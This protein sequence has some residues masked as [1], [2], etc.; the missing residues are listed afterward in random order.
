M[1]LTMNVCWIA[2]WLLYNQFG[3]N[4]GAPVDDLITKRYESSIRWLE[5]IRDKLIFPQWTDAAPAGLEPE[6]GPYVVSDSPV[7]FTLRGITSNPSQGQYINGPLPSGST[8]QVAA[9]DATDSDDD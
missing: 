1:S 2:A 6:Q 3:F 9:L 8:S 5:Q 4:P 7:G